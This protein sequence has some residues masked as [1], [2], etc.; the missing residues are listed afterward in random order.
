MKTQKNKNIEKTLTV[1]PCPFCGYEYLPEEIFTTLLNKPKSIKRDKRGKIDYF[2][3]ES[4]DTEE[5]FY[6]ENCEE[7]FI[8]NAEIEFSTVPNRLETET[9]IK[10]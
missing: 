1:I 8:V 7:P 10:R 9:V 3:G 4:L 2:V 6:C 5:S